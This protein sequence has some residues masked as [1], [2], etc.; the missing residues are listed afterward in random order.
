M[1]DLVGAVLAF[2]LFHAV[3]ALRPLRVRL[4]SALGETACVTAFSLVSLALVIWIGFAFTAAPYIELWPYHPG[5][6]WIP[7]SLMPFACVLIVAGLSSPNP[8][9]LGAGARRF[10]PV[11]PGIVAVTRHPAIWGLTLWSVAH[12]PVNGDLAALI[13]FGLLTLLGLAGPVS[14]DAER[15]RS[16]GADA[17]AELAR[18]TAATPASAALVQTGWLRILAG[19][20]LYGALLVLHGPVIGV[21]P[22]PV[23]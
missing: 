2:L 18:R 16:L 8:F 19:L 17:W 20:S 7:L 23:P 15:R 1:T 3:A 13:V 10:D 5:L 6:R 11:R 22:L 12:I 4:V 14:L 21:S 9:S